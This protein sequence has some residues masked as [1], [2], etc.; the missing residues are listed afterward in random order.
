METYLSSEYLKSTSHAYQENDLALLLNLV[1]HCHANTDT[2]IRRKELLMG[3]ASMIDADA[4][5]WTWGRG[6]AENQSIAPVAMLEFGFTPQQM[7]AFM[8]IAMDPEHDDIFRRRILS[9]MGDRKVIA[10]H[11]KQIITDQEL[12]DSPLCQNLR[13]QV[14][15]HTWVHCLRYGTP[16][17]WSCLFFFRRCDRP[18][19]SD[20][21]AA[22][23]EL[24]MAALKTLHADESETVPADVFPELSV[25]QRTVMTMLLDGL[26]RKQIAQRLQISEETVAN[27][28]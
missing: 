13:R 2:A 20:R 25:R 15:F 8:Q 27:H 23:I 28:I 6:R 1:A 16:D 17:T 9:L 5:N 19:F 18:E 7:G 24:T 4:G 22:L 10:T 3:I 26:A 12:A 14:G 21:E 11:T